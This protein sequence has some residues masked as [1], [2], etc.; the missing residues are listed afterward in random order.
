MWKRCWIV[1]GMALIMGGCTLTQEE[2]DA[3]KTQ[4]E[5][6]NKEVEALQ[7]RVGTM[8]Q[9]L[10]VTGGQETA[11]QSNAL[12]EEQ[13]RLS[14]EFTRL[15]NQLDGIT[16]QLD[17]QLDIIRRDTQ[18]TISEY[19]ED[20]KRYQTLLLGFVALQ[21]GNPAE[22]AGHFDPFLKDPN[23]VIPHDLLLHLL[24]ESY[25]QQK[26]FEAAIVQYR[27]IFKNFKK[28]PYRPN[29][30]F[31]MGV[32]FGARGQIPEQKVILRDFIRIYPKSPL[33]SQARNILDQLNPPKPVKPPE[34]SSVSE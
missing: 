25:L 34:A 28:S 13:L 5:T 8:Q 2:A 23:S 11:D 6:L 7:D 3:L 10:Q 12:F 17:N 9:T 32:A 24:A 14:E 1:I 21:G 22:A 30:L 27:T 31:S 16:G 4:Q 26:S 15:Q 20:Q 29:A 33:A 18:Q 19:R